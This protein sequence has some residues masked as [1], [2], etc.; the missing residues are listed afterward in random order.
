MLKLQYFGQLMWKTDSLEKTLMLGN[1]EG[2]RRRGWQE[3]DGWMASLTLWRWVWVGSG[4]WWWTG[5]PGVVFKCVVDSACV[6]QTDAQATCAV[7]FAV[8]Y[9]NQGA[10]LAPPCPIL[11]APPLSLD[12]TY[13]LFCSP[14]PPPHGTTAPDVAMLSKCVCMVIVVV[15]GISIPISSRF[16]EKRRGTPWIP[17]KLDMNFHIKTV[18]SGIS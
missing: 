2:R 3:W 14:Y 5:K 4:S 9:Y 7:W 16:G 12:P 8:C 15:M 18:L 13:S 10:P 6:D 17:S 1:T 11:S